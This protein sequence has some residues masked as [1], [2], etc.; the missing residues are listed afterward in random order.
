MIL[1]V[2]GPT[3]V[4][5]SKMAVQLAKIYNGEII[6][7]D[8][9]QVYREMNVGTAKVTP[10]EKEHIPHHLLDIRSINEEYTVFDYQKDARACIKDIQSR[11]KIP[12]LVGGSGYYIKAALY[13]YN[14]AL[15]G[16]EDSGAYENLTNKELNELINQYECGISYDPHNH[17][18]LMRLASKL[19]SGWQPQQEDFKLLYD[20]VYFIGLTTDRDILYDRISMRFKQMLI[21]LIDEV[22]GLITKYPEAR[23]FQTAIGYKEFI[24]FFTGDKT[25]QEVVEECEKATRNYAKRQYTWFNNQMEVTWFTVNF[26]DFSQTVQEVV[27]YIETRKE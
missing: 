22:K 10:E 9:T 27:N 6:N 26:A 12:I 4:G 19:A 17:Q 3:A 7:A 16:D 24:P 13:D 2:V 14:F 18:R 8:S 15:E 1:V 20:D 5:K 21:P 11:G 23:P 25:L